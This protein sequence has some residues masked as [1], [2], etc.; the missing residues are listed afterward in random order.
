VTADEFKNKACKNEWDV[1]EFGQYV[2][3]DYDEIVVPANNSVR[4]KA[5][6]KFPAWMSW[7]VNGCLTYYIKD[8]WNNENSDSVF[9]VLVRKASFIDVLLWWN[10]KR[11][12]I[13]NESNPISY[14]YDKANKQ[15]NIVISLNNIWN[16]D[17]LTTLSGTIS[18]KFGYNATFTSEEKKIV[19]NDQGNIKVS[20]SLP[21]YKMWYNVNL[22]VT[23][24]PIFTFSENMVPDE[25]KW[26]RTINVQLPIFVFP[27]I[28]VYC[29]AWLI[30]FIIII[31]YISKHF[32]LTKKS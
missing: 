10:L 29:L 1:T 12:L 15:Y 8:Q 27:W 14:S 2:T 22:D 3:Q 25:L 7:L 24:K 17:E 28:L 32:Q 13:L 23:T 5:H 19:A 6:V 26:E 11:N 9:K 31:V 4:Q 16:V 20:L 18:N 21:R 30:L